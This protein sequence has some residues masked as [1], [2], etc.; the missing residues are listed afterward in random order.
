MVKSH[1]LTKLR[2]GSRFTAGHYFA[3]GRFAGRALLA[4]FIRAFGLPMYNERMA[5]GWESKAVDDQ[6][7]DANETRKNG[8]PRN[9]SPAQ[10][11]AVR[12]RK[13]LELSRVRVTSDLANNQDPRYRSLLLRALEDLDAQIAR[14]KAAG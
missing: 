1:A 10:I 12:Q 5:R 6:I 2:R 13:V 7:Q 4:I 3:A 14:L 9:L 11:D 8:N